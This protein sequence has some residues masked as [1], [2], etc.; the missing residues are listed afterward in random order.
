MWVFALG[1]SCAISAE[2]PW[3][4][5]EAGR[6]GVSSEDHRQRYGLEADVDAGALATS[7][8]EGLTI[9]HVEVRDGTADLI[10]HFGA[11]HRLEVL[12]FSSGYES[13]SVSG[14]AGTQ[15]VAQGGGDLCTW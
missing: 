11:S 6:I 14:P 7:L 15:V 4:L 1:D 12:P 5:I 3:R 2:C 8:L 10:L 9:T 13:W